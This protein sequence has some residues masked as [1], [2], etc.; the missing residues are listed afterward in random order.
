M[1]Q[2]IICEKAHQTLLCVHLE[3]EVSPIFSDSKDK[4]FQFQNM[5]NILYPIIMTQALQA[6]KTK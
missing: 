2:I 5:C 1:N 4:I 3:K 6:E